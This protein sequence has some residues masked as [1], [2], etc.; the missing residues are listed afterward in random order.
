MRL[1][2]SR[3][4]L[5]FD[6]NSQSFAIFN[7]MSK[8]LSVYKKPYCEKFVSHRLPP[9]PVDRFDKDILQLMGQKGFVLPSDIDEHVL[10]DRYY[11]IKNSAE[12][13]PGILIDLTYECNFDCVYCYEKFVPSK[14]TPPKRFS[15]KME[16]K[17]I[18]WVS[19]HIVSGKAFSVFFFGGEPLLEKEKLFRITEKINKLCEKREAKLYVSI[20]TNGYLMDKSFVDRL[21][22]YHIRAIQITLDGPREI[23]D[24]RRFL[25]TGEPTFDKIWHNIEYATKVFPP[26]TIT[27]RTNI[28][29][30]NQRYIKELLDVVKNSSFG[31]RVGIGFGKVW[32]SPDKTGKIKDKQG[33]KL[34]EIEDRDFAKLSDRLGIE[35][36]SFYKDNSF[37]ARIKRLDYLPCVAQG[38]RFFAIDT[39]GNIYKCFIDASDYSHTIGNIS[40]EFSWS[41]EILLKYLTFVPW[42]EKPCS[43][44]PVIPM[45]FGGCVNRRL[46]RE[47]NFCTGKILSIEKEIKEILYERFRKD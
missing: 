17:T 33:M 25:K 18:E 38:D 43:D 23:H 16:D 3:F 5:Y 35:L 47:K 42:K 30:T 4:N 44:C 6:I 46:F 2:W 28:D 20:T 21:S 40:K 19:K 31:D 12:F 1:K 15:R 45:C 13:I 10:L 22:K 14:F 39:S 7:A 8:A 32:F 37:K 29:K 11:R 26:F 27:I 9:F 36:K 34:C 24:K 41:N